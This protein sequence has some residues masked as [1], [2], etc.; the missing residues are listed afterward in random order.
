MTLDDVLAKAGK[1]ID[2]LHEN[3]LIDVED[4]MRQN[5]ATQDEIDTYLAQLKARYAMNR[6]D[7]LKTVREEALKA[8]AWF[9]RGGCD[10]Q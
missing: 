9:K 10:L 3:N 1:F 6:I 5:G 4:S 7:H 2:A 8:D